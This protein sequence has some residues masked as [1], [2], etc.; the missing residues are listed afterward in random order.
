MSKIKALK[1][2]IAQIENDMRGLITA[3]EERAEKEM[4][5]EELDKFEELRAD[6]EKKQRELSALMEVEALDKRKAT[7]MAPTTEEQRAEFEKRAFLNVLRGRATA[8]ER[9]AVVMENNKMVVPTY[10]QDEVMLGL[11]GTYGILS[12]VDLRTDTSSAT[13]SFP[14]VTSP[15]TL[16]KIVIGTKSTEGSASFTGVQLS[17][18]DYRTQPIPVS[19]TLLAA[20]DADLL[21]ALID[22]MVEHIG[23][24]LSQLIIADGTDNKDFAAILKNCATVNGTATDDIT[25]EDVINLMAGVKAPFDAPGRAKFVVSSQTRK[26]LLKIRDDNGHPI[27]V[28]DMAG[29]APATIFGHEVVV[30]DAMPNIAADKQV[31]LFGDLKSYKCRLVKGVRVRT[32]DEQ[33]FADFNCIGVQGFVTGDGRPV[34]VA[35]SV[36]PIAALKLKTA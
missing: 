15:I 33:Q 9:A 29:A 2:A 22:L 36:E 16:E 31:M 5:G 34:R 18:Y 24:A 13:M 11:T 3:A 30:D 19:E 8:E 26:A 10:V 17:A 23:K 35:G 7:P 4:T 32:Y 28:R 1:E 20:P 6:K 21:K 27:Y 12:H 25:Y 14:L